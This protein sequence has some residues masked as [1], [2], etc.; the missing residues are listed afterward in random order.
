MQHLLAQKELLGRIG[1]LKISKFIDL[2]TLHSKLW[3]FSPFI[4]NYRVRLGYFDDKN[5]AIYVRKQAEEKYFGEY[6]YKGGDVS[7]EE[8]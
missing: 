3:G 6:N 5:E 2:T 7:Y 4:Y 1:D 8:H